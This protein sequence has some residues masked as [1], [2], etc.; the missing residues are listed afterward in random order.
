VKTV[1]TIVVSHSF[2]QAVFAGHRFLVAV[3]AVQQGAPP[4]VVGV[5]VALFSLAPV[6]FTVPVGKL[7]DRIGTRAPMQ[8]CLALMTA[9][10]LVPCFWPGLAPLYITAP[11]VGGGFFASY[12]GMSTL[13]NHY[14]TPENRP[15][16]FA[17]L[18]VGISVAQ[19]LVPLV[20]GFSVD[21]LGYVAA[22]AIVTL[23]SLTSYLVFSLGGVK[24][25]GP[26]AQRDAVSG[27]A[28]DNVQDKPAA[29]IRTRDLLRNRDLLSVYVFSTLFI[30]AWDIFLVMVPIYGAQLGLTA[31][32]MGVLMSAYGLASFSVRVAGPWLSRR[33]SPWQLMHIA[34]VMCAASTMIFGMLASMPLLLVCA[35]VMGL[36]QGIGSPMSS[37]AMY[38][39][40]PKER[41]GEAL[42]LRMSLGMAAQTVL[43][44]GVGAMGALLAAA[45]IFWVSGLILFGG[46]VTERGQWKRTRPG[47][48]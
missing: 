24:H 38:E 30:L 20:G 44:L 47:A 33:W 23:Y 12:V 19:G 21:H 26:G 27:N 9:A 5:L 32:Q 16:N 45:P 6:L 42:G 46:V 35:F 25:I 28:A 39:V 17:R 4:L 36:G 37:A 22:F 14:S 7:V 1:L 2:N 15:G 40:A 11:M 10:T 48:S 41:V 29:K 43:P 31:S 3:Y 18:S 34:L 13:L 8:V